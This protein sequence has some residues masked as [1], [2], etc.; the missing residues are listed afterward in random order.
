MP[1]YSS[2]DIH[3]ILPDDKVFTDSQRQQLQVLRISKLYAFGNTNLLSTPKLGLM[4]SSKCPGKLILQTHDL[5]ASLHGKHVTVVSGFHSPIEKEC[6]I[7][8]LRTQVPV[9][10]CPARSLEALRIPAAWRKNIEEGEVLLLSPFRG[11]VRRQTRNLST[12]RNLVVAALAHLVFIPYAAPK[13]GTFQLAG[14]LI[15]QKK[16][17]LT[18]DAV[19]NT[20]LRALGAKAVTS[21]NDFV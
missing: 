4:C 19:Q 8:L 18:L 1:A 16:S 2:S 10:L 14:R 21:P 6:L 15:A 9:I 17:V 7:V 3:T 5:M 11:K 20:E 12:R 13:S